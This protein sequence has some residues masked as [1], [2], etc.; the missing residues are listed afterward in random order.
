MVE[1]IRVFID[2]SHVVVMIRLIISNSHVVELIRVFISKITFKISFEDFFTKKEKSIQSLLKINKSIS[3]LFYRFNVRNKK[4]FDL[5]F[6]IFSV[7]ENRRN[8]SKSR[9]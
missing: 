3:K 9:I 5:T 6:K 8:K 1:L 2:K 4:Y 7:F